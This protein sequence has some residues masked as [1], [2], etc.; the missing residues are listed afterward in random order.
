MTEREKEILDILKNDPMISQQELADKLSIA[1]SSI[2][3]HITNLM[4]KG[5][6]KGKGYYYVHFK[7]L[8]LLLTAWNIKEPPDG[9]GMNWPDSNICADLGHDIEYIENRGYY[10]V[11]FNDLNILLAYWNVKEPPDGPGIEPN[12]LDCP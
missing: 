11:H 4:K 10:R 3:V 7:D 5:Y 2:A 1:R 12:C 9:P 8:S 6:I